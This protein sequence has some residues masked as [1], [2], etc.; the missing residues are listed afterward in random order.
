MNPL[1]IADVVAS[2]VPL[3][4]TEAVAIIGELCA[5]VI[6]ADAA[7]TRIPDAADVVLL[8][9]GTLAIGRN[10]QQ[11]DVVYGAR[12]LHALLAAATT[13]APLRLFVSRAISSQQHMSVGE[14]AEA[15]AYYE[16]PGRP[17]LL[18]KVFERCLS[19]PRQTLNSSILLPSDRSVPAAARQQFQIPRRVAVMV[20]VIAVIA[21]S[22]SAAWYSGIRVSSASLGL[23]QFYGEANTAVS[24]LT[25][26][27]RAELGIAV[28]R[29]QEPQPAP[30][31]AVVARPR[32]SARS[33]PVISPVPP[34]VE[35]IE[36]PAIAD[37]AEAAPA[38][39]TPTLPVATPAEDLRVYASDASDVTPATL[40]EPRLALPATS[41]LP[42][43]AVNRIEVTVDRGGE[44]Q[45]VKLISG[46]TT[47][48]D[49]MLLSA[50]KAWRFRPAQRNGQPVNYRVVLDWPVQQQMP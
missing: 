13:P 45:R 37:I 1:S 25:D 12:L 46:P 31:T 36:Q 18:Q 11:H 14:F 3:D 39:P 16:R 42:P 5:V 30:D 19:A 38:E 8:G 9:D 6:A 23:N 32:R 22:V 40:E 10:A 28:P 17:L 7:A 15:L 26:R 21:A 29:E 43:P 48:N 2:Q 47:M 34:P 50:V 44:V 4:W 24:T 49:V 35:I 20:G 33:T 27:I 41:Q